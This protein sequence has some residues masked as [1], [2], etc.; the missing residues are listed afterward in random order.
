MTRQL[1]FTTAEVGAILGGRSTD[2]VRR[3]IREGRLPVASEIRRPSGRVSR[4]IAYDDLL[5]YVRAY[6]RKDEGWLDQRVIR[7]AS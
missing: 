7:R 4:R 6:M 2:F 1:W 5:A 3:E